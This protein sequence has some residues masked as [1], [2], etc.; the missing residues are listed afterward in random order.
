MKIY[1][2]N[3][4]PRTPVMMVGNTQHRVT[5]TEL[6]VIESPSTLLVLTTSGMYM[7]LLTFFNFF[8]PSSFFL[9]ELLECLLLLINKAKGKLKTYT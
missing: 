1:V 2:D 9:K 7:G 8:V 6:P 5:L 3:N 4:P